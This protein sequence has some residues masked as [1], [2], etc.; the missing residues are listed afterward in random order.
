MTQKYVNKSNGKNILGK[1]HPKES[2][3]RIEISEKVE[4]VRQIEIK[5]ATQ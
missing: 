2:W 3:C 5:M 4:R 1:Y